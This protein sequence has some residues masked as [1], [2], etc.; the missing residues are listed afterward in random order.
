MCLIESVGLCSPLGNYIDSCAAF[1]C[2]LTNISEI[3][4]HEVFCPGEEDP[5]KIKGHVISQ[6][7]F[8]FS[9]IARHVIMAIESINDLKLNSKIFNSLKSVNICYVVPDPFE[10]GIV[11]DEI[12]GL[13]R[14]ERA[15]EFGGLVLES[16]CKQPLEFSIDQFTVCCGE[17]GIVSS[18]KSI[19]DRIENNYNETW[20]ILAIDSLVDKNVVQILLS[21]GKLKTPLN[22]DGVVPG[23]VGVALLL[24][25]PE[26]SVKKEEYIELSAA[27]LVNEEYDYFSESP[28]LG[29]Q[30]TNSLTNYI[31]LKD[32]KVPQE[33][34]VISS[35]SGSRA[36]GIEFGN[37]L[38]CLDNIDKLINTN[39]KTLFPSESYGYI[40]SAFGALAIAL[41]GWL[42]KERELINTS[43]LIISGSDS[44]ERLLLHLMPYSRSSSNV[45]R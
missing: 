25:S 18:L 35:Y 16:L 2:G 3:T 36:S 20:L 10:R 17:S 42:I 12:K 39:V 30:I 6:A 43:F 27:F 13:S 8:G 41:V 44:K 37:I 23:E 28:S 1:E 5:E 11:K 15:Q 4:E 34:V 22:S 14:L 9:A 24:V 32:F 45:R 33:L 31:S 29:K 26:K 21:E 38:V 7:T 19:E 40:G